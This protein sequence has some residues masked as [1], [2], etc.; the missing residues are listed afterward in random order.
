MQGCLSLSASAYFQIAAKDMRLRVN[1]PQATP[2]PVPRPSFIERKY[3]VRAPLRFQCAVRRPEPL[4]AVS[5]RYAIQG[6]A[7]KKTRKNDVRTFFFLSAFLGVSR[8]GEF[9]NTREKNEYVSKKNTGE[10]FFRG[11]IVFWAN[12]FNFFSFR[13][14]CCVG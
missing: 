13:F 3:E 2:P 14:F 12:V 7:E 10:I 6:A 8:Q 4:P 9:E 1:P 5:R 11:G